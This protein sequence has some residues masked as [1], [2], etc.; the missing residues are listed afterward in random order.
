MTTRPTQWTETTI[1][2]AQLGEPLARAFGWTFYEHPTEGDE[3][4]ILA[5][6]SYR[7]ETGGPVWNTG[8]YDIPD[9]L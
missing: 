1:R 7:M 9:Y 6:R 4:P 2:P 8:D 5:V 3:A